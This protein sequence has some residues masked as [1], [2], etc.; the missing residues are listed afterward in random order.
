M[1]WR[2]AATLLLL[3][4]AACVKE[5]SSE[6]RLERETRAPSEQKAATAKELE[7]LNCTDST[8]ALT[9]ARNENQPENERV[10]GYAELYENLA[11]RVQTF[12]NAMSRNPDFRYRSEF[13]PLVAARDVCI[14]QQA[15]VGVEFDRYVRELVTVPTVQEVKGGTTVTV[16]RLDYDVLR[17]A[18][19][20][21]NPDDKDALLGRVAAAEK[22]VEAR[23]ST[24]P[25]PRRQRRRPR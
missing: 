14:Q 21:L 18:I 17:D 9:R 24:S 20:V 6:E 15:D 8:Q 13:Q 5:I 25:T 1:H 22:K 12:E 11:D 3:S 23:K 7:K 4:P 19:E 2:A 10:T 16:A